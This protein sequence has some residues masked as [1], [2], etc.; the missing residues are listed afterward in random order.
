M[1]KIEAGRYHLHLEYVDVAKTVAVC[2]SIVQSRAVAK[3]IAIDTQIA[4]ELPPIH[5]DERAFKQVL[6]NL[7][8]NAVKF[9]PNGGK[10]T[11]AARLS[12]GG[13][14]ELCVVDHGVGIAEEALA[15]IF[16]PFGRGDHM[17]AQPEE[18][19]GLGLSISRKLIGSVQDAAGADTHPLS[20]T[21]P[22]AQKRPPAA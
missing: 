19:I 4:A 12:A 14:T 16:E 22:P 17:H 8:T 11:V 6:L 13:E 10:I 20:A 3:D 1:S 18:G 21:Q 7:L 9:S 5:A 15:C 2:L